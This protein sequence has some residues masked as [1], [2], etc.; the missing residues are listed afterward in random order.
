MLS[1]FIGVVTSAMDDATA[2]I[3]EEKR[4]AAM[5]KAAEEKEKLLHLQEEMTQLLVS[6]QGGSLFAFLKDSVCAKCRVQSV[7]EVSVGES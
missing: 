3:G 1:I 7:P 5:K 6:R 2:K 4:V